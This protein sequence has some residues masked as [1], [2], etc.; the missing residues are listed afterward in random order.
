MVQW[1]A[2]SRGSPFHLVDGAPNGISALCHC[3]TTETM[4]LGVKNQDKKN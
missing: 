1:W 4:K 3:Y 2:P